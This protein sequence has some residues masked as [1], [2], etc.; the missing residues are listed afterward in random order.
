MP[1]LSEFSAGF[2]LDE[3]L[4]K[5][6]KRKAEAQDQQLDIGEL[7]LR[8]AKELYGDTEPLRVSSEASLGQFANQGILPT[9][10]LSDT[11]R[12]ANTYGLD[13]FLEGGEVPAAVNLD[14]ST[15]YKRDVLEQ[16]FGR[17]REN[18]LNAAPAQG[19]RLAGSLTDLEAQRALGVTGIESEAQNQ[20]QALREKLYG[21]GLDFEQTAQAEDQNLRRALFA[22]SL[23]LGY[24]QA[25]S[26]LGGL[27]QSSATY[28]NAAALSLQESLEKQRRSQE[29]AQFLGSFGSGASK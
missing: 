23:G 20:E 1:G 5:S 17:A 18:T 6:G 29:K 11:R 12:S 10:F 27:A 4:T 21:V 7:Q 8:I 13:Q 26:A 16:Q 25:D 22:T 9:P 28:G 2:G 14:L 24:Q 3:S 19:G 15:A